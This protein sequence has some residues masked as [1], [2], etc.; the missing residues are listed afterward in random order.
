MKMGKISTKTIQKVAQ[1]WLGTLVIMKVVQVLTQYYPL[2]PRKHQK[3]LEN[4]LKLTIFEKKSVVLP[5]NPHKKVL[6]VGCP[7]R[8]QNFVP[9]DRTTPHLQKN[10]LLDPSQTITIKKR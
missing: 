2:P 7:L 6:M 4:C 9:Q 8:Q 1:Q 10:C 5:R 3:L